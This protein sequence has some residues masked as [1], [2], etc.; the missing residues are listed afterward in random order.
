MQESE[1]SARIVYK[2]HK[3][4]K[5][6]PIQEVRRTWLA[7]DIPAEDGDEL[8]GIAVGLSRTGF[9]FTHVQLVNEG[10]VVMWQGKPAGDGTTAQISVKGPAFFAEMRK[11]L[12]LEFICDS[13]NRRREAMTVDDYMADITHAYEETLERITT[14]DAGGKRALKLDAMPSA[15]VHM[16]LADVKTQ[17]DLELAGVQTLQVVCVTRRLEPQ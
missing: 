1:P 9:S 6:M 2:V 17:R 12:K 15:Q 8:M 16:K 11:A 13:K 7:V 14:V 5:A 4:T 3:T 10:G